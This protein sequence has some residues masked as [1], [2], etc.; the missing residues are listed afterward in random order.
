MYIYTVHI[1]VAST[2]CDV[3]LPMSLVFSVKALKKVAKRCAANLK[4]SLFEN[5]F[6][7]AKDSVPKTQQK[8]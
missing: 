3:R 2:L 6:C 8:N 7:T 5:I 1:I 4:L